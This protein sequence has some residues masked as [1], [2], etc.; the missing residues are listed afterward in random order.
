MNTEPISETRATRTAG[1]VVSLLTPVLLILTT[2]RL[3]ISPWYVE[4]E[5]RTPGFPEDRYGFTKEERLKWSKATLQYLR[6]DSD[7]S[8]L[9]EL[10]F[11]EG[12]TV[13]PN[14]CRFMEDCN[15][16]YNQRELDHMLDVKNVVQAA[17][18]VWV[19]SLLI[20]LV[21][22]GWAWRASRSREFWGALSRGGRLTIVFTA[23]VLA[24]VL[25]AFGFIFVL[26]HQIFFDAGT[27]TF[28]YSDTLI[29]L[30]PERFWR[31]TFLMVAGVPALVGALIG[32]IWRPKS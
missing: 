2:V 24:F 30:Y 18:W 32:Y 31:D 27:W 29:R 16:L 14:S 23:V 15:K 12:Q 3:M 10:R 26:F 19:G 28:Y 11:P 1:W 7:I 6:D 8:Y 22:G 9:A 21:I 17:N 20:T 5:Y 4:F 25:V 13:P